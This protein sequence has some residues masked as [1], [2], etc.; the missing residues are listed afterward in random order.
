MFLK[1]R[2]LAKKEGVQKEE[3]EYPG[4]KKHPKIGRNTVEHEFSGLG[5]ILVIFRDSADAYI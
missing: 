1:T 2:H 3:G 5:F 4:W